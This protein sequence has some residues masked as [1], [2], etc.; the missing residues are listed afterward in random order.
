MNGEPDLAPD[1]ANAGPEVFDPTEA[2]ARLAGDEELLRDV[3]GV[4]AEE[5]PRHCELLDQGFAAGDTPEVAAEVARVAH[6][7]K[8]VVGQF[9]GAAL[10]AAI[11]QVERAARAGDLAAAEAVWRAG[12]QAIESFVGAVA[13]WAAAG[14]AG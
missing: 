10:T 4:L 3:A 2:I 11:T 8:G 9:S 6:S 1:P 14:E 13:R 5:W 7:L 12:I